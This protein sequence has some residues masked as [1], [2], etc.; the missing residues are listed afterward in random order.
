MSKCHVVRREWCRSGGLG[1]TPNA[2]RT[3]ASTH[4]RLPH[5]RSRPK[6]KSRPAKAT[7][8]HLRPAGIA[9]ALAAVCSAAQPTVLAASGT[10]ASVLTARWLH[11]LAASSC[12][13]REPHQQHGCPRRHRAARA[14]PGAASHPLHLLI[15]LLPAWAAAH[16]SLRR[17]EPGSSPGRADAP[18]V[19]ASTS[20]CSSSKAAAGAPR[21]P[22]CMLCCCSP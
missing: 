6:R 13:P 10:G 3:P 14:I 20:S 2:I 17:R 19:G 11:L 15:V 1:A 21:L 8:I 4:R 16:K 9:S 18:R 7:P 22:C 12:C 5:H